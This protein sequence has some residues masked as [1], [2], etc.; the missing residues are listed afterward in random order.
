MPETT[1]TRN[2]TAPGGRNGIWQRPGLFGLAVFAIGLVV[3]IAV[4]FPGIMTADTW[5]VYNDISAPN[6]GDWQSPVM[7]VTW[8]FL[9]RFLPGS[10]PGPMFLLI[11]TLYWAA[12]AVLATAFA[13]RSPLAAVLTV[14]AALSPPAFLMAGVIWRDVLMSV[15]WLLAASLALSAAP[16]PRSPGRF[17]LQGLGLCL[18][19]FGLLMR[20]NA[21]FAAPVLA[22]YVIWPSA[23]SLKRW[24]LA[25]VPGVLVFFAVIQIMFYVVLDARRQNLIHSVFV[26]DIGGM[27]ALTGENLFPGNWS[28]G[29]SI[30]IADGCYQ[31]AYWDTYWWMDPC[32]WVM[33]RLDSETADHKK[34]FGTPELQ[35]Y[36]L[37]TV[38]AHPVAYLHHRFLH[39][40]SFLTFRDQQT[41][42]YD[43]VDAADKPGPRNPAFSALRAL[44]DAWQRT[45][46]FLPGFWLLFAVAAAALAWR[47][48][49]S[50]GGTY[51]LGVTLAALAYLGTFFF[52]GVASAY[53]YAY[54]PV[55]ADL[56]S[57]AALAAAF[58]RQS[59]TP[60]IEPSRA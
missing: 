3:T 22:A 32:S 33:D 5:Y 1:R 47:E 55:L 21:L 16:L 37:K 15:A 56:T 23:F 19:A 53:R 54:W 49:A 29:E 52:L 28:P 35:S 58:R 30:F 50:P 17:A 14:V 34:L 9:Q 48:R 51:V 31:P 7:V 41:I 57:I 6:A 38:L 26:F 40:T 8:G 27:S 24:L 36:W 12:F 25:Y 11:A 42:E 60:L 59:V 44:H 13:R 39:F 45:F 46:I 2:A 18:V 4:Y 20:P 43:T 10:P